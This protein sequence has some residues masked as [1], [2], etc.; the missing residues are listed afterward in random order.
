MAEF[1]FYTIEG[2]TQAPNGED[3]ENCQVLGTVK[4]K[5]VVEAQENLLK[6]NPW[7]IEAGYVPS[8]FIARQ[9]AVL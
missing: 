7:I 4:G 1:I 2:F 8:E 5:D 6:E 9:L 3:F